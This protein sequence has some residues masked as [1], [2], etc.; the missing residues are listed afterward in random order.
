MAMKTF[1]F[2]IFAEKK[3]LRHLSN[4]FKGKGWHVDRGSL[5]FNTF[6]LKERTILFIDFSVS[7][8]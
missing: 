3:A 5:F 8:L 1:V 2:F 4:I 7:F 6:S